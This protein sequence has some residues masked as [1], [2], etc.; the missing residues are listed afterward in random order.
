[1]KPKE[2]PKDKAARLRER[3][4]T[5]VERTSSAEQNAQ[6]LTSDLM[7]VYGMGKPSMFKR[8]K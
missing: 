2:D 8:K 1:M 3:R 6:S 5:E 7:A 4:L